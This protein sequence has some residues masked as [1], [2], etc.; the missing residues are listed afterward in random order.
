MDC[1]LDYLNFFSN[2]KEVTFRPDLLN[3]V[4][5]ELR[6]T[7]LKLLYQFLGQM[8]E[9]SNANLIHN[10]DFLLATSNKDNSDIVWV[11]P[12]KQ[13]FGTTKFTTTY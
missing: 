1:S 11:G 6:R 4:D 5:A 10:A 13:Q 8:T 9:A 3:S 7:Q 2:D 12:T